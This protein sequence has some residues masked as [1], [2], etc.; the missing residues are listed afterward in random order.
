MQ[1]TVAK[2]KKK[3]KYDVPN[4]LLHMDTPVFVRL[5]KTYILW[6]CA[7]TE[8]RLEY[9]PGAVAH[10]DTLIMMMIH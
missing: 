9:L 4:G 3:L 6:L 10:K 8:C 7:D 1:T 5:A 2:S